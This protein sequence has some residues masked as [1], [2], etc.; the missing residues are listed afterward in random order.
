MR[1]AVIT[2]VQSRDFP[3]AWSSLIPLEAQLSPSRH[4][5]VLLNDVFDQD[6]ASALRERPHTTVLSPGRNLGVAGGRNQL[7]A[8]AV[9]DGADIIVSLDDDLIVVTD[10]LDQVVDLY[11]RRASDQMGIV[12]FSV[13]DYHAVAQVASIWGDVDEVEAGLL[14]KAGDSQEF[15]RALRERLDR[16]DDRHVYHL[17]NRRWEQHYLEPSGPLVDAI[18]QLG[19]AH[20]VVVARHPTEVRQDPSARQAVY[21]GAHDLL[22]VDTVPGGACAYPVEML[23]VTG[24]LD[25]AFTPFGY[26]DAEFAIRARRLGFAN[27]VGP[28]LIV[29]HDLQ[30]RNKS[31]NRERLIANVAKGRALILR[32]T[33]QLPT[34]LRR[35]L[36]FGFIHPL[37]SLNF[38][39]D[40]LLSRNEKWERTVAFA[41]GALAGTFRPRVVPRLGPHAVPAS[42]RP[43]T[44]E[45]ER[46]LSGRCPLGA[47]YVDISEVS[48]RTVTWSEDPTVELP[49]ALDLVLGSVTLCLPGRPEQSPLEL[50]GRVSLSYTLD[51]QAQR[52][53]VSWTVDVPGSLRARGNLEL[54]GVG[55]DAP[56]PELTTDHVAIDGFDL[57]L[58]DTG[59]TLRLLRR[60]PS[61]ERVRRVLDALRE[62]A[63]WLSELILVALMEPGIQATATLN[64][65]VPVRIG[66]MRARSDEELGKI[67]A[68]RIV[69][70]QL[71]GVG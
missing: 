11:A 68:V 35:A 69:S 52:F 16:L 65:D 48:V 13:L 15:L 26:E 5:Y 39:D 43:T 20:P 22:S 14:R 63:P 50:V 12:G 47:A 66:D 70:G 40:A 37:T 41:A 49:T 25:E 51:V 34:T 28:R 33:R 29:M 58:R 67:I 60:S 46:I 10:L 9:A 7:I 19:G 62:T 31:R 54:S 64:T 53:R 18:R 30:S 3:T 59:L 6:L 56:P 8:R 2:M 36:E 57:E 61:Q 4:R 21:E 44:A 27:H 38:S 24:L 55:P 42:S 32:H 45:L 1:V 23:R 71:V 17:G